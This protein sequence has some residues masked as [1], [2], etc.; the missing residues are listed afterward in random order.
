MRR[1]PPGTEILYQK[2]CQGSKFTWEGGGGNMT[3]GLGGKEM[4]IYKHNLFKN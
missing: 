3:E 2:V 4:K 1:S